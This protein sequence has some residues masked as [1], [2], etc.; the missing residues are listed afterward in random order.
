M[1]FTAEQCLGAKE[2]ADNRRHLLTEPQK[3]PQ[4]AGLKHPSNQTVL[5][6]RLRR[7]ARRAEQFCIQPDN[8]PLHANLK[9][10]ALLRLIGPLPARPVLFCNSQPKLPNAAKRN[11]LT[12][13]SEILNLIS[14]TLQSG[15]SLIAVTTAPPLLMPAPLI[16]SSKHKKQQ[17][18]GQRCGIHLSFLK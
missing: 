1:S 11:V 16:R 15:S 18:N 7:L 10:N 5:E 2:N 9:R 14:T 13:G 12:N 3:V 6:R 8:K 4:P 17:K